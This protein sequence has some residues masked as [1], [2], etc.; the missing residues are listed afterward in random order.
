MKYSGKIGSFTSKSSPCFNSVRVLK[1][2][3]ILCNQSE[4]FNI[5]YCNHFQQVRTRKLVSIFWSNLIIIIYTCTTHKHPHW[6]KVISG[7]KKVKLM[8]VPKVHEPWHKKLDY[9]EHNKQEILAWTKCTWNHFLTFIVIKAKCPCSWPV[10]R[11]VCN[12][13]TNTP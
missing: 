12:S 3:G 6:N 4:Q 1:F 10:N 13:S 2:K 9:S 8:K 5:N 7:K 11:K